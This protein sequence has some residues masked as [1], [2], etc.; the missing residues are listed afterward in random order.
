MPRSD[1]ARDVCWIS[2]PEKSAGT[3]S[4][5][6]PTATVSPDKPLQQFR[7]CR[8]QDPLCLVET[9]GYKLDRKSNDFTYRL[10]PSDHS[11][12]RLPFSVKHAPTR[13]L[14][15]A[16]DNAPNPGSHRGKWLASRAREVE[17]DY[18][19]NDQPLG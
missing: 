4:S 1:F 14:F 11:A 16:V 2:T 12:I 9:T 6:L 19:V 15:D 3:G 13:S 8:L 5:E 17:V 18:Q 10:H 7:Q